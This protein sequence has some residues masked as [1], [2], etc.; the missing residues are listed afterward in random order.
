MDGK[1][2]DVDNRFLIVARAIERMAVSPTKQ[3]ISL[4]NNIACMIANRDVIDSLNGQHSGVWYNSK[5]K[6]FQAT[7]TFKRIEHRV[8]G[9][10]S[11]ECFNNLQELKLKIKGNG[12]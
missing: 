3:Q 7:F 11:L 4:L 6:R 1:E 12:K 8:S 9:K 10:T 2:L 5:M